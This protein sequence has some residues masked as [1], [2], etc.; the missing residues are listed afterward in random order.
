MDMLNSILEEN[1]FFRTLFGGE[2]RAFFK[3]KQHT[4]RLQANAPPNTSAFNTTDVYISVL[5]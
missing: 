3:K 4:C 1:E 2:G 5:R